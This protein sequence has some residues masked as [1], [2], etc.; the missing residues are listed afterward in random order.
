MNI[1]H[2]SVTEILREAAQTQILPRYR[3]LRAEDITDKGKGELVTAADHAC[4]AFLATRLPKLLPGS[5][6]IGEESVANDPTLLEA[7]QGDNPVWVVD[8]LDGTKNFASGE[9]PFAVMACLMRQ[10]ETLAAWIHNPADNSVVSAELGAGSF[11]ADVRLQVSAG[12]GEL[13]TLRGALLT[14]FLPPELKPHAESVAADFQET[15]ATLCA[16]YDYPALVNNELQFLSYYRT[17]VWDHA[18]GA[19]IATEAGATVARYDGA[20]YKPTDGRSGLLCASDP[21][22][23]TTVRNHL[24]P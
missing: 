4:E 1:P 17:L 23:W 24:F 2:Q 13:N 14:K 6:L 22:T 10:G 11:R 12:E 21:D 7:L 8:P 15:V 3:N 20:P 19:L 5:L 9:G 16:G 18:P